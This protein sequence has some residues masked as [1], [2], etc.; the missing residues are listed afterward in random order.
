MLCQLFYHTV[1][2]D[3]QKLNICWHWTN[4]YCIYICQ[5]SSTD[6]W[7]WQDHN[8]V[9]GFH[10]GD[11]HTEK[12]LRWYILCICG[13]S[14]KTCE[15][16]LWV[17]FDSYIHSLIRWANLRRDFERVG[18]EIQKSM[19]VDVTLLTPSWLPGS[20]DISPPSDASD[21]SSDHHQHRSLSPALLYH[22]RQSDLWPRASR[23]TSLPLDQLH[24]RGVG[25]R[26]ERSFE[27]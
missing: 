4:L 22:F 7:W 5:K 19:N 21:T 12:W 14:L 16:K 3:Y 17:T 1:Y 20:R 9:N 24:V 15:E 10:V 27:I 26:W 23:L 25:N 6:G 18:D 11:L 8:N 13:H 2:R